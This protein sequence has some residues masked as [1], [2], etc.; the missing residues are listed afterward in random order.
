[1]NSTEE[2]QA[3]WAENGYLILEN[4]LAPDELE[5]LRAS[6]ARIESKANGLTGDSDRFK[7]KVFGDGGGRRVQSIAEP[8]ELGGEWMA[9]ARHPRILDVVEELIGPNIQL[10]YSMLMMKPP[11]EG[12]AAP[13]HQDM[14]FFAHDRA[15]LLAC[16][17]YLDDST[18][19][20]GCIRVVPGSHRMGLFNHYDQDGRFTGIVTEDISRFDEPG[21]F[22]TAPVK[23][24]GALLWHGLTLH[25]SDPNRSEKPRRA[26]V[27][28]Y[29]DPG[30]RLLGGAFN[31]RM[32][33][34]TVGL[35]VRGQDPSGDLLSA[36]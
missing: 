26:V 10:Y 25:A 18:H 33:V 27:F 20:N 31:A 21:G 5:T 35:M 29:K 9:L 24:G 30:A 22:V 16:Q 2:R 23:A 6:L 17:V 13:W 15:R 1:M 19:E 7:F 32:E 34:R 3:F 36:V 11:L 8:H 12:F 14:A 4:V 28:E